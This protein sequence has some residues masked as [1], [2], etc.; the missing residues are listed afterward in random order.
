GPQIAFSIGDSRVVGYGTSES[1][2]DCQSELVTTVR[3][4]V[5]KENADSYWENRINTDGMLQ[6]RCFHCIRSTSALS[7]SGNISQRIKNSGL[8]SMICNLKSIVFLG[9]SISFQNHRC[10]KNTLIWSRFH[11]LS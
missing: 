11:R 9:D 5:V 1:L 6:L 2:I 7:S 10:S 8:Q 4:E 3:V